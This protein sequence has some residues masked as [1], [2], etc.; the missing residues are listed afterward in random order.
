[1]KQAFD[2]RYPDG[3]LETRG[4]TDQFTGTWRDMMTGINKV[5]DAFVAPFNVTAEYLER[6]AMGDIPKNR[7][8]ISGRF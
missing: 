2:Y 8:R 6:I 1:M 3:K 7:G 4:N 5:I